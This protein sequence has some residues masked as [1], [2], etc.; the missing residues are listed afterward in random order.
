MTTSWNFSVVD[1]AKCG[2]T[3]VGLIAVLLESVTVRSGHPRGSGTLVVGS[4]WVHCRVI[5]SLSRSDDAVL[6]SVTVEFV[7]LLVWA[8]PASAT[9]A[10]L[11]TR[12]MTTVSGSL[13]EL[14]ASV[15]KS[16]K[17]RSFGGDA[18]TGAVNVGFWAVALD[19]VTCSGSPG[20]I[21]LPPE[22]VWTHW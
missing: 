15:T 20:R 22:S 17:N 11:A 10:L 8:A 18:G 21:G 14:D 13:S 4:T 2:A 6:L 9:G 5:G 1:A 7:A 12:W 19:S 16:L 3:N